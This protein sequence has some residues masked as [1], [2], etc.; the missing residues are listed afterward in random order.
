MPPG[1]RFHPCSEHHRAERMNE[2]V[3]SLVGATTS[4]SVPVASLGDA[5]DLYEAGMS[6]FEMVTL[7]VAIEKRFGIRFQPEMLTREAFSSIA[8]ICE[9]VT[10][11]GGHA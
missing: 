8:A 3:R 5:S 7:L 2:A 10:R 1:A 9:A 4:L 6:S 11:A